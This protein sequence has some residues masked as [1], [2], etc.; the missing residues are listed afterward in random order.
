M[1]QQAPTEALVDIL[2]QLRNANGSG[3]SSATPA[4]TPPERASLAC[5]ANTSGAVGSLNLRGGEATALVDIMAMMESAPTEALADILATLRSL[6]G[7]T[8]AASGTGPVPAPAIRM[9]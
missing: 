6:S 3:S 5:G 9:L 2:A 4:A 8:C 7:P 1:L